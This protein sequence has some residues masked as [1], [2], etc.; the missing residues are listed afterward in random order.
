[1]RRIAVAMASLGLLLGIGFAF[2]AIWSWFDPAGIQMANDADPF[3]APPSR[4]E[5]TY[6]FVFA[7]AVAAVSS[8]ILWFGRGDNVDDSSDDNGDDSA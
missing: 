8:R 2:A 6:V 1:M 3:G 7:A 4:G 5:S